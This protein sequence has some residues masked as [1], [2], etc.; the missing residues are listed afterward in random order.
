LSEVISNC[1]QNEQRKPLE[2][3]R[4]RI[5]GLDTSKTSPFRWR[6]ATYFCPGD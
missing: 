2:V 6:Q 4:C 5:Q 1:T 3:L